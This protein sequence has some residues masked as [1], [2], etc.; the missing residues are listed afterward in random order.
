MTPKACYRLTGLVQL[1]DFKREHQITG[2][3][4]ISRAVKSWF[5]CFKEIE[6]IDKF[7]ELNNHTKWEDVNKDK[8]ICFNPS[9]GYFPYHLTLPQWNNLND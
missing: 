4:D 3:E 1:T 6:R 2:G 5:R 7:R 8:I 9:S